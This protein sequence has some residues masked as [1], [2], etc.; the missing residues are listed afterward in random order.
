[1]SCAA[2]PMTALDA[3]ADMQRENKQ[4]KDVRNHLSS[5]RVIIALPPHGK[6]QRHSGCVNV[7]EKVSLNVFLNVILLQSH[8]KPF[9]KGPTMS[10]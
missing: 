8:I 7:A 9:E 10:M 5:Y 1:M 2:H 6:R 3:E 4:R